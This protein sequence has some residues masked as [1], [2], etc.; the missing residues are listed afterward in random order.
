M[1]L[2][3]HVLADLPL[4]SRPALGG[5]MSGT[6]TTASGRRTATLIF[7][8]VDG[9]LIPFRAGS[10]R[11][12]RP[13]TEA[14]TDAH[15]GSGNPLLDRL[16]PDDGQRLLALAGELVWATTWMAEANDAFPRGSVFRRCLWSSGRTPTRS[17]ATKN[18]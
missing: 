15:D 13:S 8:D 12:A 11:S 14:A 7:L 17:G 5:P 6:V 4:W 2:I 9:V 3:E 10:T 1:P 18:S 16:N